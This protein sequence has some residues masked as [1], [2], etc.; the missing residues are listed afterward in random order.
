VL[1]LCVIVKFTAILLGHLKKDAIDVK[2]ALLDLDE[3]VLTPECLKQLIDYAPDSDEVS[4]YVLFN[5]FVVLNL[6]VT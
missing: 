5:V 1:T 2:K 4:F 3:D 6:T